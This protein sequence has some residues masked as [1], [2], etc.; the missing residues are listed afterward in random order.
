MSTRR[1]LAGPAVAPF[2]LLRSRRSRDSEALRGFGVGAALALG[3]GPDPAAGRAVYV[4]LAPVRVVPRGSPERG[5][6]WEVVGPRLREQVLAAVAPL[7]ATGWRL[8]GTFVEAA[9]WDVSANDGP[10]LYRGCWLRMRRH[11]S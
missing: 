6:S 3:G 10:E 11:G 9:R 5:D 4:A 2:P 7:L 8:G 1:L